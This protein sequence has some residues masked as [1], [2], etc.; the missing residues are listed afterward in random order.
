MPLADPL[1][2]HGRPVARRP[3]LLMRLAHRHH[4]VLR[5][6]RLAGIIEYPF[7]LT[8]LPVQAFFIYSF[9]YPC[10]PQ[11]PAGSHRDS[12]THTV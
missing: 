12:Y 2:R 6:Q 3:S 10:L 7:Y 5:S 4:S 11:W 9:V 8:Q 1:P